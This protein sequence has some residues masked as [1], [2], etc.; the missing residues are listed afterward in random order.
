[1]KQ[2]YTSVSESEIKRSI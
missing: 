2:R 1:M